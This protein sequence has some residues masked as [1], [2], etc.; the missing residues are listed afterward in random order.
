MNKL[1]VRLI[2][3]LDRVIHEPARLLLMALLFPLEEADFLYLLT[4]AGLTKGNLSTH[5]TKLEA[6]GYVEVKKE[7]RGK[8]PRTLIRLT[9]PGRT[10]FKSYRDGLKSVAAGLTQMD[11][12]APVRPA[13]K[14]SL[15]N[16]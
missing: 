4:Q 14:P 15:D 16:G 12:P 10:A 9:E 13:S 8:I 6:V 5:L 11:S 1:D 7:F 2:P 3:E